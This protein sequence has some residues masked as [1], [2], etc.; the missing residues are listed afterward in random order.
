MFAAGATRL[1]TTLLLPGEGNAVITRVGVAALTDTS[2][3]PVT[4]AFAGGGGQLRY[5]ELVVDSSGAGRFDGM[6]LTN[7]SKPYA[8]V[9]APSPG[10]GRISVTATRATAAT[11]TGYLYV[12]YA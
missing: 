11:L 10:D 1:E 5:A 9:E 3:A 4:V 6:V 7:H 12:D 8:V 2:G